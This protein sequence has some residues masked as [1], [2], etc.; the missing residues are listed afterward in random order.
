MRANLGEDA[1]REGKQR[2]AEDE[3]NGKDD[4]PGPDDPFCLVE[5]LRCLLF[6][7]AFLLQQTHQHSSHEMLYYK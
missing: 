6:G 7:N 2:P 1:S 3:D 5:R 4:A